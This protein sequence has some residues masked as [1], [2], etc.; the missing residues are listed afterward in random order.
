MTKKEDTKGGEKHTKHLANLDAG[1]RQS[2]EEPAKGLA[3]SAESKKG[4]HQ[5][6]LCGK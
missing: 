4:H 5:H 1:Q 3:Q 2:H 6:S